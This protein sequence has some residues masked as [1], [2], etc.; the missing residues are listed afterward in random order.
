MGGQALVPPAT[1]AP[2]L[3]GEAPYTTGDPQAAGAHKRWA[4]SF[5]P[6]PPPPLCVP[7]DFEEGKRENVKT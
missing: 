7:S 4:H 1:R 5:C 2:S 6:G 3:P